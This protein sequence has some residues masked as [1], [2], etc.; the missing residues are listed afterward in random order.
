M[1]LTYATY[2]N[3]LVAMMAG[4]AADA[5]YQTVLPSIIDYSEQRIYRELD[6]I[7]TVTRDTSA[8][9]TANS[10]NFTLP[11]ANGRFV[12]VS[13][14]NLLSAGVRVAQLDP[15]SLDYLDASWPSETAASAST[16]PQYFAMLTDQ[17][18]VVGP[19]PGSIFNVE[20]I[21]TIRPAP[22]SNSNQ[23]TFLTLYLPD[24]FLAASMIFAAGYQK[25]F[26]ASAD[27]PRQAQSWEAQYQ[28]LKASADAEE[29]RKKFA[30]A[31]WT[32][33]RLEPTAQPQRG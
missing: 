7:S 19:P 31:S 29:A 25:N 32:S 6:L 23:T 30:G 2:G 28:L 24:L 10:R 18:V 20:V 33:K 17:T 22:L 9:L 8:S 21:G 11:T 26:G 27:D 13:G 4:S 14:L 3:T 1:S 15:A 5:D 16:V 12:V